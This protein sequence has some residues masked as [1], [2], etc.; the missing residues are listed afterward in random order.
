METILEQQRRLHEE[1]ERL[2]KGMVDE[3]VSRSNSVSAIWGYPE[4]FTIVYQIDFSY[5]RKNTMYCRTTSL[6]T[7]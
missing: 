4:S 1:R 5:F 2:V 6:V 3:L 7:C